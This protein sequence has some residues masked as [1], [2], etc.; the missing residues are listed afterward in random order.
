[1]A[2]Q[3][4]RTPL[5]VRTGEI[6]RRVVVGASEEGTLVRHVRLRPGGCQRG[7]NHDHRER[8]RERSKGKGDHGQA[9]VFR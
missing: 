7:E 2:F 6:S 3:G 9:S 4:K 1:M 5:I 8:E